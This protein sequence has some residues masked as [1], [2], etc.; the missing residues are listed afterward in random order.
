[1]VSEKGKGDGDWIE[2]YNAKGE[3]AGMVRA[4]LSPAGCLRTV[5][6]RSAGQSEGQS[7]G[8]PRTVRGRSEGGPRAVCG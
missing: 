1:M 4:R 5:R 3:D 2:L 6:G 7:E 8:G